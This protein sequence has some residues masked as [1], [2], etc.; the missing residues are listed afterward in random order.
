[1]ASCITDM[2]IK[3]NKL[4]K[5]AGKSPQILQQILQAIIIATRNI[6]RGEVTRNLLYSQ[7]CVLQKKILVLVEHN[8][9]TEA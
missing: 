9:G 1:M 8:F 4:T 6:D 2:L 7:I 5:R 3:S